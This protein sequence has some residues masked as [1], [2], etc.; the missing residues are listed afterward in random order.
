MLPSGTSARTRPSVKDSEPTRRSLSLILGLYRAF[1]GTME[2]KMENYYTAI[3]NNRVYVG[4]YVFTL[5]TPPAS[6][7]LKAAARTGISRCPSIP[8]QALDLVPPH[9]KAILL[10][11]SQESHKHLYNPSKST[12]P[13]I[14]GMSSHRRAALQKDLNIS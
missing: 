7:S 2:K 6:T 1:L 9:P 8:M 13:A 11:L 3:G 5:G 12:Y 10:K 14:R 4:V